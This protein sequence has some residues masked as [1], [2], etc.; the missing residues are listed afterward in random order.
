MQT[1]AEPIAFDNWRGLARAVWRDLL[2]LVE[3]KDTTNADDVAIDP[4]LGN[5][6]Q[7]AMH[8]EIAGARLALFARDAANVRADLDLLSSQLERYYDGEDATVKAALATLVQV[9]AL[10]LTPPVPSLE[11]SRALVHHLRQAEPVTTPP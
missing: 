4:R 8:L 9:R 3:V 7:Q 2:S 11:A 5:F 1:R 10:D 6:V